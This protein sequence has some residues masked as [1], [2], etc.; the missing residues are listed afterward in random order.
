[1]II[2]GREEF[3]TE[4]AV[5]WNTRKVKALPKA[6]KQ[7]LTK[8]KIINLIYCICLFRSPMQAFVFVISSQTN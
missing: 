5:F 2:L 7:K 4:A 8:V 1:M 6:L 3:L